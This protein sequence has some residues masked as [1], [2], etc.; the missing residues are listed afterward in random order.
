MFVFLS[1]ST[2]TGVMETIG[3]NI[4]LPQTVY[5]IKKICLNVSSDARLVMENESELKKMNAETIKMERQ[6]L[7][8]SQSTQT[9]QTGKHKQIIKL[10]FSYSPIF[11]GFKDGIVE[12]ILIKHL[13][14]LFLSM[15]LMQPINL[16]PTIGFCI[17][18]WTKY[19]NF[20]VQ[21]TVWLT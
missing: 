11:Q 14:V 21:P 9:L 15:L 20:K 8:I 13:C 17:F 5:L 6:R 16:K 19:P 10:F 4:C 18:P 3:G 12:F 2:R 1:M 7:K